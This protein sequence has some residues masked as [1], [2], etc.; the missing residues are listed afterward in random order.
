MISQSFLG[1][2]SSGTLRG[3]MGWYGSG[4]SGGRATTEDGLTLSLSKLFCDRLFRPGCAWGGSLVWTNTTT[5]ERV[6]TI[7]YEAHLRQEFGR[8][9]LKYTAIRWD[10]SRDVFGAPSNSRGQHDGDQTAD[11]S[12]G[13]VESALGEPNERQVGGKPTMKKAST[14]PATDDTTKDA[15]KPPYKPT[16]IEAK[17][18]AAY[19]AAK[20]T[21]GPRLKVAIEGN[22]AKLTPDHPDAAIGTLAIMRAIGTADLD[23]CDGLTLQLVN[24]SKGQGPSEKAV[25]FMLAVIKGIEPR[26]EIEAML[27]A[28]MAAVH[29]ASMTFARR[30]AHVDTI[31]QQDS[32][33]N[34]FNKLT[35]T[36]AAQAEALKRYRSG[37]E[38]KMTVQH[39][40]VAEGGQAIVG[41]VNASTEGVGVRKKSEVQ[42]HALGYAPG[43]EMPREIEAE[44]ATV[45]SSGGAGV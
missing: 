38:Q 36:F 23:F 15:E 7:G 18:I 45:P 22:A 10:A 35:R 16:P 43:V 8:M 29:M 25:N 40:H 31:Q 26:D 20:E 30:L 33:S 1:A 39:V 32:A 5:H 21:R 27:A 17:A 19:K 3:S 44:R 9:R 28:Q 41:N 12:H 42:P 2:E 4:R 37:G 6:G 11:G 34:A 13:S 24:A 14:K